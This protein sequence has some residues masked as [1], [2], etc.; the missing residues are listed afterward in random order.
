MEA[1]RQV[2]IRV[3]RCGS[4]S[5]LPLPPIPVAH[6]VGW[7]SCLHTLAKL[8]GW[9]SD[10]L[11]GLLVEGPSNHA[12]QARR[13]LPCQ[14]PREWRARPQATSGMAMAGR[15][16]TPRPGGLHTPAKDSLSNV[17]PRAVRVR[18]PSGPHDGL[19]GHTRARP[20]GAYIG[21]AALSNA[22][23]GAR[24][25][26]GAEHRALRCCQ[27]IPLQVGLGLLE[28]H[29]AELPR[30]SRPSGT[31]ASRMEGGTISHET[32][33]RASCMMVP[34]ASDARGDTRCGRAPD[35]GDLQ[36]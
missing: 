21:T 12:S 2:P 24:R 9:R 13:H 10:A 5:P 19:Q 8:G 23:A 29:A 14:H 31:C 34:R 32:Q 15:R 30:G 16:R 18:T 3:W 6:I 22:P 20:R 25:G 17:P 4:L 27:Q 11:Q 35:P 33:G 28:L 7:T 36:Q 26:P 1:A